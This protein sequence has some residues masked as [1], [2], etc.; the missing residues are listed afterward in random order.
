MHEHAFHPCQFH[1]AQS[2]CTVN[3]AVQAIQIC[4]PTA[5]W[6]TAACGC[7]RWSINYEDGDHEHLNWREL[8]VVLVPEPALAMPVQTAT[9]QLTEHPATGQSQ[10]AACCAALA[11]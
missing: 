9:E 3:A 4:V 7:G 6:L 10:Q 5:T 8:E 2:L 1:P 11:V